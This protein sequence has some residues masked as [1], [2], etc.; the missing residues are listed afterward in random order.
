[1]NDIGKNKQGRMAG[2]NYQAQ[3]RMTYY[4]WTLSNRNEM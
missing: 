1:M 2:V 4:R 3:F